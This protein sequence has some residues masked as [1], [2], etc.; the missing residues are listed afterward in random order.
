MVNDNI[1]NTVIEVL[2]EDVRARDSD[3]WLIIQVLRKLGINIYLDYSQL[4][5][6]PSFE[7]I[8]RCR[9]FI[10]NNEGLYPPTK[11]IEEERGH[12]QTEFRQQYSRPVGF[13]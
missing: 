3:K 8:T 7:I 10:Q 12:K 5:D 13:F 2:R 11:E 4:N 6:M 9:R 1:R